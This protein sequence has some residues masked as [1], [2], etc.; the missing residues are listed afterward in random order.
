MCLHSHRKQCN[1]R[2][3]EKV[4]IFSNLYASHD[5]IAHDPITIVLAIQFIKIL[6][7]HT[8]DIGRGARLI[9]YE[10]LKAVKSIQLQSEL[11]CA[12][13]LL[14][15]F[16]NKPRLWWWW[17]WVSMLL[18]LVHVICSFVE[19]PILMSLRLNITVDLSHRRER[20]SPFGPRTLHKKHRRSFEFMTVSLWK[21]R[22][23]V[24]RVV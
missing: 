14:L 9:R 1:Q 23:K 11:W 5:C 24:K 4:S 17:W 3:G 6:D 2:M 13:A 12:C 21:L 16:P 10:G 15:L 20:G 22:K 7:R 19:N 8:W 18:P